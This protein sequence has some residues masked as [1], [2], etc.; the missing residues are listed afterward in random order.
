[1]LDLVLC[2]FGTRKIDKNLYRN[3]TL[4]QLRRSKNVTSIQLNRFTNAIKTKLRQFVTL[5]NRFCVAFDVIETFKFHIQNNKID[6]SY[7]FFLA[8][9]Q[10]HCKRMTVRCLIIFLSQLDGVLDCV[11]DGLLCTTFS[12]CDTVAFLFVLCICA[13]VFYYVLELSELSKL[14]TTIRSKVLSSV[15]ICYVKTYSRLFFC[16]KRVTLKM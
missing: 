11:S 13:H 6:A 15:A 10:P 7:H 5:S 4:I 16:D 1:M 3:Y 12:I 2:L 9:T 8:F 14:R